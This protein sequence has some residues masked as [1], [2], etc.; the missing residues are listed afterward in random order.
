MTCGRKPI[1]RD[2]AVSGDD[3]AAVTAAARSRLGAVTFDA[4][5]AAGAPDG[6]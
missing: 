6:R 1:T 4:W 5:L 2:T 3:L